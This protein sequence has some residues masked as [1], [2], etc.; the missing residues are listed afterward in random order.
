MQHKNKC[1]KIL[2]NTLANIQEVTFFII[3]MFR[4]EYLAPYPA[5]VHIRPSEQGNSLPLDLQSSTC[6]QI[7]G[8]FI[9][10]FHLRSSLLLPHQSS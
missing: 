3:R 9:L 6:Q 7:V 10:L 5:L 4:M 1:Y 2:Y 8:P